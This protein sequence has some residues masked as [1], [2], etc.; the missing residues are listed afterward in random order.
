M[1]RILAILVILFLLLVLGLGVYF[2]GQRTET[3]GKAVSYGNLAV[4][5]SYTFASPLLASAN[6]EEKIRVTV[7]AL[8]SQGIGIPGK[9][10]VL[11][12]NKN[13]TVNPVQ[14]TTD[15]LGKA[16]F[17]ISSTQAAEYLIEAQVAGQKL[18]QTVKVTFK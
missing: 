4:E 14:P 8:D 17:D 16:V 13:L 6:G 18:S 5:N 11:G 7:F 1:K 12:Q 2:V 9:T 10:V 3:T 15:N